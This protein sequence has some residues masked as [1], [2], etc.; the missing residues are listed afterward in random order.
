M[1]IKCFSKISDAW[2]GVVLDDSNRVLSCG[3]STDGEEDVERSILE[4]L[5]SRVQVREAGSDEYALSLLESMGFFYLGKDPKIV[6][7]FAWE[8]LP[9]FHVKALQLTARIPRGKVATYG[10]IAAGVGVPRGARAVGNAEAGNP[11]API[12]PCHRVIS[13]TLGLGGYGGRLDVKKAFL[14]REGVTFVGNRVNRKCVWVPDSYKILG[15]SN[16]M[17]STIGSKPLKP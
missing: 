10:G 12:I 9:T 16:K 7:E 17:A 13:S 4:A 15:E 11:F 3:F 8:H 14:M 5:P 6:P 1:T 2:F